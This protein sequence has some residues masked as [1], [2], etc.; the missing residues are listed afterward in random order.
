MSDPTR[1]GILATGLGS[2]GVTGLGAGILSAQAAGGTGVVPCVRDRVMLGRSMIAA[3]VHGLIVLQYDP[4]SPICP[5]L[6]ERDP[7][8]QMSSSRPDLVRSRD[9]AVWR[10]AEPVIDVAMLGTGGAAI[11][12]A[13]ASLGRRPGTVRLRGERYRVTAPIRL[14]PGQSLVGTGWASLPDAGI[15]EGSTILQLDG[16]DACI[17][18]VGETAGAPVERVRVAALAIVG[19]G[20]GAGIRLR[21]ARHFALT[22]LYLTRLEK[23]VFGEATVWMGQVSKIQ[24]FACRI[25]FDLN[26]GTEDTIFSGCIVRYAD[27]ACR[28]NYHSQTNYFVGCDFGYA[29]VSVQMIGAIG[30]RVNATFESCMFEFKPMAGADPAVFELTAPASQDLADYPSVSCRGCRF[31][32][33]NEAGTAPI[34]LVRRANRI[35]LTDCRGGGRMAVVLRCSDPAALGGVTLI[36][37]EVLARTVTTGGAAMSARITEL[38]GAPR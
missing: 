33:L 16:A 13:L 26:S 11:D 38:T 37:N 17:E 28:I 15:A 18:I 2:L 4:G 36:G 3:D 20:E 6:Y 32:A 25:G 31:H 7:A 8:G 29:R 27:I 34:F 23:G 5:A 12:R 1:R 35:S 19:Q 10:L 21:D 30:K 14:G 22:D 9:G 24:C